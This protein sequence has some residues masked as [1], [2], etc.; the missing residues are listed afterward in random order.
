[1][2]SIEKMRSQ[3][4]ID[5]KNNDTTTDG[6]LGV[7]SW[8]WEARQVQH[9]TAVGVRVPIVRSV[10]RACNGNADT[11]G[12]GMLDLT[13]LKRDLFFFHFSLNPLPQLPQPK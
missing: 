3:V 4:E 10:S 6:W 13:C 5:E 11:N 12:R 7:C 1:M 9:S 8:L 2:G